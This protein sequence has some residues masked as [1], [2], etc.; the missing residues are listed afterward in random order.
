MLT[1]RRAADRG[2]ADFGWLD[3]RHSFSFGEYYDPAHMGF[4]PLRVINDD[5]VAGGGGFP[6]HPHRDMEIVSYVLEGALAH[7][8]S[9]GTGSVIK[10]GDVQ[11]MSAGT[12]IAHSEFNASRTDPVHFL[13]IWFLPERRGLTPG[14]E[15]KNFDADSKRDQLRLVASPDGRDGSVTIRS[16]ASLYVSLLGKDATVSH[17]VA[18]GR[19]LW[20]QVARGSV[21]VGDITLAEGD[22]LQV[23]NER[24]LEIVGKAAESE[25]LLFD[26]GA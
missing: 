1:L 8:D 23:T 16:D 15:Q 6:T 3:S 9:L 19:G 5:R 20:L 7:K 17:Q 14:Y 12:G 18:A 26:L 4:G 25:I 13:Q 21:A 11:R 24:A 22:G 10:P 2:R